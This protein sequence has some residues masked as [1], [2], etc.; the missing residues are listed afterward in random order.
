M[1]P[2]AGG[3]CAA[4]TPVEPAVGAEFETVGN[5]VGVLEVEPGEVHHRFAVGNVVPVLVGIEEKVGRVKHPHAVFAVGQGGDH[6]ESIKER[7]V[8][9][10]SAV[11]VRVLVDGDFVLP[12]KF[13]MQGLREGRGRRN[14]VEDLAEMLVP[15]EDLETGG[16]GILNI[17]TL[18]FL[19]WLFSSCQR[20]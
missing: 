2:D 6:V 9:V 20:R 4:G 16:I 10:E 17:L 14:L 1:D 12:D 5:G 7:L 18:S 15:G 3:H 13:F 19:L 11:A 8:H